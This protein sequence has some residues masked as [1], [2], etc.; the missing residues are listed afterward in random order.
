MSVPP[1]IVAVMFVGLAA[2]VL[3]TLKTPLVGLNVQPSPPPNEPVEL[4][5]SPVA[6]AALNRV[7]LLPGFSV[8]PRLVTD[9]VP[10]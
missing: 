3:I 10:P 4:R 5:K 8:P 9:N 2:V 6:A 1:P 7:K